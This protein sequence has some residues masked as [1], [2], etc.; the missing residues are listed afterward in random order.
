M[1]VTLILSKQLQREC[2]RLPIS[3]SALEHMTVLMMDCIRGARRPQWQLGLLLTTDRGI[4]ILNKRYRKQDKPTDI[5]SFPSHRIKTPGKLPRTIVTNP[6][7]GDLVLSVPYLLGQYQEEVKEQHNSIL[8]PQEQW[9]EERL[10]IL[11]AHGLCHLFGY[12]HETD[13][14]YTLMQRAE[15]HLLQKY[16]E[17]IATCN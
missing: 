7:L 5:L 8:I 6:H 15:A 10:E 13:T 14:D 3:T 17:Q 12:D 1:A 16:H 4:H 9:M 2:P 11:I